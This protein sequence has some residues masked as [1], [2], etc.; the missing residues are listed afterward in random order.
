MD[1]ALDDI[2]GNLTRAGQISADDVLAMRAQVYGARTI[3]ADEIRALAGLDAATG[4]RAPEW[5]A[6]LAEAMTDYV[7]HQVDPPGYVVDEQGD[8][9]MGLFPGG[10]KIDGSLQALVEV[11]DAADGV[12]ARLDAF[13]LAG[14]RA[15]M[16]A[17]GVLAAADVQL[18]RRLVFAGGGEGNLA[19]T[20]EEADALFDIHDAARDAAND[21]SWPDFFAK[22]VGASL[23]AVSPFTPGTRD[24]AVRDEAWLNKKDTLGGF[25]AGMLKTPDIAGAMHDVLHPFA[26]EEQEWAGEETRFEAE[27]AGAVVITDDEAKWLVSRLGQ[28]QLSDAERHLIGFIRDQSPQVSPLLQPLLGGAP[29]APAPVERLPTFGQRRAPAA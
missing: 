3:D 19:V 24:E 14:A 25:V 28:G 2:I 4:E 10:L 11:L 27:S 26:D 9:L 16:V 6:F 23:V 18:L 20:R 13:V 22:T 7:V 8:W 17:K 1:A 21:A 12:P 5:G 15:A 29:T